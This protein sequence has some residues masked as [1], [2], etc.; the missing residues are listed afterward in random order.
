MVERD[1]ARGGSWL[2]VDNLTDTG[3]DTEIQVLSRAVTRHRD[4]RVLLNG[5]NTVIFR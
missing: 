3:R 4:H 2:P 1:V 5:H